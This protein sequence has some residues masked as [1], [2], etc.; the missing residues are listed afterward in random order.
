MLISEKL[1]AKLREICLAYPEAMEDGEGVGSPAF[2]VR[3][4]IFA[5]HHGSSRAD[6]IKSHGNDSS[7]WV[8]APAGVQQIRV[9]SQPSRYF[10]PPYV[11]HRGWVGVWL[12]DGTD[13]EEIAELVDDSY[14]MTAPKRLV[15]EI[16]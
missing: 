15:A 13:W 8:K 3:G 16:K 5:M 11:G 12:D 1:L 6:R 10:V 7:L 14:R 4:K 2:K 9:S